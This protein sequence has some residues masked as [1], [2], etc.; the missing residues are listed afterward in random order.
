MSTEATEKP[1]EVLLCSDCFQDHGLS[2]D[3][4]SF[5][6]EFAA[7]CPQCGSG[8]GR[9]LDRDRLLALADTF[10]V[11]GTLV[12]AEYGAAPVLQFNE[13][14]HRKTEID[15]NGRLLKDAN[16]LGE[17]EPLKTL[18]DATTRDHVVERILN[19]FPERTLSPEQRI[20]RLRRN[21]TRPA[22]HA[23]GR[24]GAPGR[25]RRGQCR[26]ARPNTQPPAW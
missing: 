13:H 19:E 4:R 3:A 12:R 20:V 21:P 24:S 22:E 15:V 2:L 7:A 16:L 25:T 17:I 11:R 26:S 1:V 6:V 8:S 23:A 10:F 14:H 18:H 9:K 5:G